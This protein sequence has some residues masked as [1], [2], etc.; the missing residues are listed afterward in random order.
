M[1]RRDSIKYTLG[2]SAWL[3]MGFLPTQSS[4][5]A[6]RVIPSSGEELPCVGLGTWQTFDVGSGGSVRAPLKGVLQ[7]LVELGGS[8]ID[9]SPMYGRSESVVGELCSELGITDKIFGATK[10]WIQG[11]EQ[12]ISQMEASMQRMA[13]TPMDLMQIHNLLDWETHIRTL[14]NWKEQGRIRYVGITH[15]QQGAYDRMANIMKNYP[16]DFIQANYSVGSPQSAEMLFPLAQD[17]GMA[18][19]VNRPYQGGSLFR[20]VQ[21]KGLPPW[22]DEIGCKSWAEF[23][24][25][26]ILLNSAVT[27][28]IPGTSK[29]NHLRENLGAGMGELPETRM[30]KK[31]LDYFKAL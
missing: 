12:G 24:L 26:F 18:V 10:V 15:Y 6:K 21:G 27:C 22:A 23:F 5:V 31:M 3:G 11:G 13:Q 19:L 29:E 16:L 28:A 7:A 9:S 1:N 17:L 8:V 30:Q 14:F 4:S 20:Q 25:K 2:F